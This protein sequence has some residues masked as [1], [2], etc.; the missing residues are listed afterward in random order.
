MIWILFLAISTNSSSF[1]K[2]PLIIVPG[3]FGSTLYT[4]YENIS[5]IPFY[6]PRQLSDEL[7]WLNTRFIIPPFINCFTLL[8]QLKFNNETQTIQN[9]PGVQFNV[10]NFGGKSSVDYIVKSQG[11]PINNES[12]KGIISKIKEKM[13]FFDQFHTFFQ[14]FEQ[15]NYTIG[16]NIFS[17]P[18]DW[19]LAPLFLDDFWP[20]FKK[21]IEN[22]YEKSNGTKVTLFG[23]SMGCLMIQQFLTGNQKIEQLNKSNRPFIQSIKNKSDI[24]NDKWI[25]KYIEKV[26]FMAPNFGGSLIIDEGLIQRYSPLVPFLR[27]EYI[28]GMATSVP[29]IHANTLNME[30]FKDIEVIRDKNGIN[31]TANDI[32]DIIVNNSGIRKEDIPILDRSFDIMRIAPIDIGPN[33]PLAIIFNSKI[34]TLSFL[35]YNKGFDKSPKKYFSV[36]GDGSL[37]AKGARY[38]C[39]N[40]SSE[41]RTLL[42]IDLNK[43]N[44]RTCDHIGMT[45]NK[46]VIELIFNITEKEADKWWKTKGKINIKLDNNFEISKSIN[47]NQI[48]AEL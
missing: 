41:N 36:D 45:S 15:K 26:I 22:A 11:K 38:A 2:S 33:I 18:Y 5:N 29:G 43:S 35:D 46:K 28:A 9:F 3:L 19:R 30:I 10:H 32:F 42:C 17:V 14:Y 39:E 7:F 1:K 44:K 21:L 23:H 24:V 34:K 48:N 4:T 40:W 47:E 25:D 16:E 8:S 20:N 6:C 13:V 12:S 27:N 37:L 31:Y